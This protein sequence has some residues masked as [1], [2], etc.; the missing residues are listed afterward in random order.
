MA[1]VA[2]KSLISGAKTATV[3]GSSI[4]LE[5]GT[6]AF[7]GWINVSVCHAAT[8]VTG[9]IQHSPDN[10]SWKDLA[11]FAAIAGTTGTE[12]IQITSNVFPYIRG[13]ATLAGAT[14][15]ATVEISFYYDK[16]R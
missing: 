13:V 14:Q 12:A 10:S 16:Q 1:S 2:R 4:A 11:S 9:K 15:A 6:S 7:I 8:T 5:S 3:T